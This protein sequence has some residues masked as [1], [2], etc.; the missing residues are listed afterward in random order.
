ML[1]IAA[2]RA[3]LPNAAK[4]RQGMQPARG[5]GPRKRETVEACARSSKEETVGEL[6]Q[7]PLIDL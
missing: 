4:P 7:T 5:D 6:T 1:R 3:K 2:Q